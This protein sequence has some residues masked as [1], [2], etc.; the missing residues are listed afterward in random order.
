MF[1]KKFLQLNPTPSSASALSE[2]LL[3]MASI[4]ISNWNAFRH[5][6]IDS[7]ILLNVNKTIYKTSYFSPILDQHSRKT[8]KL[9]VKETYS[10]ISL[11]FS[12]GADLEEGRGGVGWGGVDAPFLPPL[13]D[14]TPCQP[15]WSP[16]C[17][18]L[19]YP[20]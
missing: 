6:S 9:A 10:N 16:L 19:K 20:F 18:T 8:I 3:L 14:S 17:T 1:N 7:Q 15:K 11:Y 4:D 12:A 13:R 5:D 2:P